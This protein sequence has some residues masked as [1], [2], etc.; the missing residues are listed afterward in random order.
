MRADKTSRSCDK[1][2]HLWNQSEP[3]D[4]QLNILGKNHKNIQKAYFVVR[5]RCRCR[6][7][8]LHFLKR[9]MAAKRLKKTQK[10]KVEEIAAGNL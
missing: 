2:F 1:N 9:I 5:L 6:V 7:V 4:K 8:V 10:R 3:D